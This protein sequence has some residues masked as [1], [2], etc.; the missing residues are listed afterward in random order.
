MKKISRFGVESF[1]KCPKCFVLNYR[2]KIKAPFKQFTLN[3]AVDNLFKNEFDGYRQ[4]GEPHPIFIENKL[5]FI[6][7][8]HPQIN[9]WR[10]NRKG[11]YYYNEK[12]DFTFHGAVDDVWQNKDGELIIADVKAT[13]IN[14]FDP[15]KRMQEPYI[16]G[17]IRQ[18]EMYQWLFRHNGFEVSDKA[19][20]LYVNGKKNEQEFNDSLK[21]D[22][23]LI[24]IKGDDS[25]VEDKTLEAVKTMRDNQLPASSSTCEDCHYMKMRW[26]NYQEH[27]AS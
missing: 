10:N 3:D 14:V 2:H 19:Y 12:H 13:A 21:F 8:N 15:E 18:L 22:H 4:K 17:Y 16:D 25:W 7:F 23:Y 5:D 11:V 27:Y 20:L 9:D 6:P 1:I 24:E 26:Q